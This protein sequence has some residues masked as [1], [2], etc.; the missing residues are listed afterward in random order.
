[1]FL[2]NKKCRIYAA[3][4]V[5]QTP[6]ILNKKRGVRLMFTEE[7]IKNV[8]AAY[9]DNGI[10]TRAECSNLDA[11]PFANEL[12]YELRSR[13]HEEAE[14]TEAHLENYLDYSSAIF[15]PQRFTPTEADNYMIKYVLHP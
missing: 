13:G 9:E 1:L 3:R 12:F 11:R 7:D 8:I 4:G 2:G 6:N 14:I 10:V 15:N 5:S